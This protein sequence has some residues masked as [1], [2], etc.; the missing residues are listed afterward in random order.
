MD[1]TQGIGQFKLLA[2]TGVWPLR[3]IVKTRGQVWN[4]HLPAVCPWIATLRGHVQLI[5]GI[6]SVKTVAAP[7]HGCLF[8]LCK[9]AE[10]NQGWV[11]I[12]APNVGVIVPKGAPAVH[13]PL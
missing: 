7:P 1:R 5:P 4:R 3:A 10:G 8:L 6:S 11:T 13:T 12:L 9:V 2:R